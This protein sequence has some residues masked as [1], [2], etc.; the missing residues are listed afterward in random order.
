[1]V[2]RH[3]G[4]PIAHGIGPAFILVVLLRFAIILTAGLAVARAAA[5]DACT[6]GDASDCA[7][8]RLVQQAPP[9]EFHSGVLSPQD[10]RVPMVPDR[11]P[12]SSIGRVNVIMGMSRSFCTG[13]L[14]GPRHVIT[15]AHCLFDGKINAF[16]KPPAV[17]FV[18]AQ[19]QD[20]FVGHSVAT[21]FVTS[22]DFDFMVGQRPRWDRIGSEM[23]KHDWAIIT[24]EQPL[25]PAAV[26]I[27]AM[28][29][30]ALP[31]R[32]GPGEIAVAGYGGDRPFLLSVHRGCAASTDVPSVGSLTD[33]CDSMPG[34]S[35]SPVLLLE[36]AKAWLIGIH[37]ATSSSFQPG[38]GYRA[39]A[40]RG[41]SASMFEQAARTALGN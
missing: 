30:S 24:L 4:P 23:I 2:W 37:T 15:A 22:P 8:I 41:V 38:V 18:A 16:V 28:P 31:D 9:T 20:K 36:G 5:S 27:R 29:R 17:H 6:G 35:G 33:T 13:T 19:A 26:A 12:W 1:M 21:A 10:H 25:P 40:G 32:D 14:I 3:L 34:E 39:L 11:W 7:M